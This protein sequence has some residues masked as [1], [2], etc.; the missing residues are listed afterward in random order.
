[1]PG[2]SLDVQSAVV[3]GPKIIKG[4]Y[5]RLFSS[6]FFHGPGNTILS[7]ING[8]WDGKSKYSQKYSKLYTLFFTSGQ[9][10]MKETGQGPTNDGF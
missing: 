7:S 5:C 9:C 8:E 2:H 1:M 6:P 10:K 4:H 3:A